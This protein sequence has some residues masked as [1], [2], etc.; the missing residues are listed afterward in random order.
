MFQI[1]V[2][3][4]DKTSRFLSFPKGIEKVVSQGDILDYELV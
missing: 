3:S 2:V 1:K 4:N